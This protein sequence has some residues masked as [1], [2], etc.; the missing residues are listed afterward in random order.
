ME[1]YYGYIYR[2][3]ILDRGTYYIG[4]ATVSNR[5]Y[6]NPENPNYFGSGNRIKAYIAKYGTS[7]LKVTLL[8]IAQNKDELDNLEREFIGNHYLEENCWNLVAGGMTH[9]Y[10]PETLLKMSTSNKGEGNPMFGKKLSEESRKKISAS[11]IGKSAWNKGLP[12]KPES[13]EK[14]KLTKKNQIRKPLDNETL[15]SMAKKVSA[16]K[17][18]GKWFNNG[19]ISV[20]TYF[21]P[22]GFQPGRGRLAVR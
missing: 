17:I 3:D 2:T 13:I 7:N 18:G 12:S 19:S 1:T 10:S 22:E 16:S 21:C 5:G 20:F 6:F 11:K 9:G 4:Q 8:A 15:I 14:M